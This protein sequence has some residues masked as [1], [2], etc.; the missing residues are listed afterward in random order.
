M[1]L[2]RVCL[3]FFVGFCTFQATAQTILGDVMDIDAG[4]TISNVIINNVNSDISTVS[5]SFGKFSIAAANGHLLEFRH[6]EYQTIRVRIPQGSIP[7]YFR[8]LMAKHQMKKTEDK[9]N[10]NFHDDSI[11]NHNL[12]KSELE[13]AQLSTI[14]SIS[15][16]FSALSKKNRQI[17]AFQKSYEQYEQEK[18][19]DYTFNENI[20][21]HITGLS[22]DSCRGFLKMYRP[23]YAKLRS[24]KDYELLQYIKKSANAYRRGRGPKYSPPRSSGH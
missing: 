18:Y 17:W 3:L 8:I 10:K 7:P 11:K 23:S 14:Q 21:A 9:N 1:F 24:M 16:P 19:I 22:G 6:N 12:Y 5:D 4:N 13:F 20:V 2:R 15:H